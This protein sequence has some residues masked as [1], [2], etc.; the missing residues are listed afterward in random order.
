MVVLDLLICDYEDYY[1]EIRDFE[2]LLTS[3]SSLIKCILV[4]L[5]SITLVEPLFEIIPDY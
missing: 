2:C 1:E 3:S 4:L 5:F